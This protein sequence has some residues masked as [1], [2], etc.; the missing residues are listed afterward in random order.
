M[1]FEV[2][3]AAALA[4]RSSQLA[5][6]WLSAIERQTPATRPL[7]QPRDMTRVLQHA[8]S[9]AG[10]EDYPLTDQPDVAETLRRYA[11]VRRE[12]GDGP[13]QLLRDFDVL[14]GMLERTA[15]LLAQLDLCTMVPR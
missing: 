7:M 5:D 9:Y 13:A 6:E 12:D 8:A 3:A 2:H 4:R 1:N 15:G 14:A 11:A 10:D